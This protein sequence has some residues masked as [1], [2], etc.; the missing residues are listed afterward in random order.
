MLGPLDDALTSSRRE[1]DADQEQVVGDDRVIC[2]LSGGVDSSVAAALSHRAVGDQLTCIF[3]DNGLLRTGRQS[4]YK[5]VFQGHFS[6]DLH[7]IMGRGRSFLARLA[8]VSD[9]EKKRK[10]IGKL[11]IEVFEEEADAIGQ[12]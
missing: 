12:V 4:G 7:V 10:I 6:M 5:K 3:V 11:F 8:G 9:P 1:I 2:A